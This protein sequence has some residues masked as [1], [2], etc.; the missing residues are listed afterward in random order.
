MRYETTPW[1]GRLATKAGLPA[2]FSLSKAGLKPKI[3][4]EPESWQIKPDISLKRVVLPAPSAPKRAII[5][6]FLSLN[7]D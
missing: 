5:L 6:P 1:A 2:I 3:E 4:I 7:F